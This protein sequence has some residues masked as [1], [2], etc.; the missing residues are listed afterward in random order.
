[1]DAASS[2]TAS[3][4]RSSVT[5]P[6][7][8]RPF[9]TGRPRQSPVWQYFLFDA[10]KNKS[11]CQVPVQTGELGAICGVEINGKFPTNLK[12]HLKAVHP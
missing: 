6:P 10:S 2:S 8:T 9:G 11:I 1:M 12:S 5:P 3:R 7:T 4:S